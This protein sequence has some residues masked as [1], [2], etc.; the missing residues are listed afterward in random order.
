MDTPLVQRDDRGNVAVLTMNHGRA[1]ALDVELSMAFDEALRE[2]ESSSA[3]AVVLTGR[4][5]IFSAGADLFRVVDASPADVERFLAAL[6][7][8]LG[9][10]FTF[11]RPVV[12]AINGHAIAGG[13]IIA[14]ACDYRLASEGPASI[15]VPELRVGVPFPA[16]A[17]EILRAVVPPQHVQDLVYTGRLCTPDE[18]RRVGL[19]DHVVPPEALLERAVGLAADFTACPAASFAA[20]K[21]MLREPA[22]ERVARATETSRRHVVDVWN[23][24]E[25]RSAIRQY[26]ERTIVKRH[27]V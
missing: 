11:P 6:G 8:A 16:M 27:S 24:P 9:R 19:V 5:N 21:Q 20:T 12:A 10:I 18:A 22:M 25:T 15:G 2:V 17:L 23:L 7:N 13:C 1:N 4:G 14:C 26:I 3:K